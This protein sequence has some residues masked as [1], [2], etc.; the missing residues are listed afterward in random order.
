MIKVLSPYYIT[1]PFTNPSTLLPC[2]FFTLEVF[3]YTGD[4]SQPDVSLSYEKTIKNPESLDTNLKIDISNLIA[5]FVPLLGACWVRY[6]IMYDGINF[7]YYQ[8]VKLATKGYTYGT[9]SENQEVSGILTTGLEHKMARGETFVVKILAEETVVPV[10]D[11]ILTSVTV[12]TH[13]IYTAVFTFDPQIIDVYF[14]YRL[15]GATDW[16]NDLTI[17][18]TSPYDVEIDEADGLYNCQVVGFDEI[19]NTE[20][21]SNTIN[22]TIV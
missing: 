20:V 15:D 1:V 2:E 13:P 18:I 11:L 22:L 7:P 14:R 4:K 8:T 19:N 17:G 12:D 6:H 5:E 10:G 21:I 9:E 16:T 3:I